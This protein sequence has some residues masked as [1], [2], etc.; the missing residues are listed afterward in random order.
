MQRHAVVLI[1]CGGRWTPQHLAWEHDVVITTFSQLSAGWGGLGSSGTRS[2]SPL[3]RVHWL[4][5]VL[6]EGHLLG[7]SLSL[8]SK[9]QARAM[10]FLFCFILSFVG[11]LAP[12]QATLEELKRIRAAFLRSVV[13]KTAH[14]NQ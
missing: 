2:S 13:R 10:P 14:S 9:L 5:V 6:D 8:T 7:A 12:M 4:R 3:L 1:L 11:I